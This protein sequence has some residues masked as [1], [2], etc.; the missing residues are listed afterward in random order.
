GELE[1]RA[2]DPASQKAING[3]ETRL[4]EISNRLDSSAAQLAG[5]DPDLIRSLEAQV[6]GLSAHLARPEAPLPDF[7]DIVPR[8]GQ[9][10][11]SIATAR[12]SIL[13][14]ARE[15]A[16]SAVR[17]MSGSTVENTAVVGLAQDLKTLEALT[18]RSD[19]R[20]A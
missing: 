15:A 6:T 1:A 17:S 18:R 20:N 8:L 5:L 11:Q 9:I 13:D 16:E 10:E 19:D 12:D 2:N 4:T 7:D 14:V 3:L